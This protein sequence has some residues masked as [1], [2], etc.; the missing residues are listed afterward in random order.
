MY[1]RLEPQEQDTSGNLIIIMT[2]TVPSGDKT[3]FSY[4]GRWGSLGKTR[5]ILNI[6]NST[7]NQAVHMV[8]FPKSL[9]FTKLVGSEILTSNIRR[10]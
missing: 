7:D 8:N 1:H 3:L 5:C 9:H 10:V 6:P 2:T 4:E